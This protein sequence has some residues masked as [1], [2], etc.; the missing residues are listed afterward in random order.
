MQQE[1]KKYRFLNK[2]YITLK[3]KIKFKDVYDVSVNLICDGKPN[4]Y[5]YEDEDL[6]ELKSIILKK[7]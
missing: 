6:V 5:L 3:D 1:F 7:L 4:A 2:S